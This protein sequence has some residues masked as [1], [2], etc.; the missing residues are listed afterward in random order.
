[1]IG[2]R[3][4]DRASNKILRRRSRELFLSWCTF[5]GR[6]VAGRS[7]ELPELLVSHGRLINPESI[8]TH[9]MNGLGIIRCHRH[10]VAA[11]T[12]YHRAH[13]EFTA[14]NQNHSFVFNITP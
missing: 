7:Y 10:L 12:I 8:H 3:E 13:A 1:M 11:M 2:W 14:G 4:D 9:A 6:D 5:G